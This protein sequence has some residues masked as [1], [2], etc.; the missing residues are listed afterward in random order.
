MKQAIANKVNPLGH[1]CGGSGWRRVAHLDMSD[2]T[3]TCPSNWTLNSSPRGCGQRNTSNFYAS[4][5][6]IYPVGGQSYSYVCGR[7]LAYQQGAPE[8]FFN[9]IGGGQT[10]VDSVYVD[11]ISVTH[12]PVGSRQHIWTF[13]AT[14]NASYYR[15][16]YNCPCTNTRYNWPDQLPSFIQNNYFC[17]TGNPGPGHNDTAYYTTDPLWDGAGCG[18]NNACCQFNNPPW[19]KSTLPLG[20]SDNIEVRFCYGATIPENPI[21]Y[22]IEIYVQ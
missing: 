6:T 12:G 16:M 13:A 7:I 18:P 14:R 9:S 4:D 15:S 21:V 8:A 1:G 5:S 22:L 10:S 20:T 3:A 19:F 2:P 11:G 17:D